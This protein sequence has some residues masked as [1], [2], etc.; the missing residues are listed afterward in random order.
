MSR[1][2]RTRMYGCCGY[3]KCVCVPDRK[4][5]TME[6]IVMYCDDVDRGECC[7]SC[8][9][10]YEAGYADLLEFYDHKGELM[11]ELCCTKAKIVFP[12]EMKG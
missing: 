8:H 5:Q 7:D 2:K 1:G 11:A 3:V 6:K 10:D 4:K 12:E 9:D